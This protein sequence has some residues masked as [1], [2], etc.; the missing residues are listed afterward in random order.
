MAQELMPVAGMRFYIG[1]VMETQATDFVASDFT[2][3]HASP[4]AWVE[5]DGWEQMGPVGDSVTDIATQLINRGRTTHQKGVAD[6]PTMTNVFVKIPGD[7]GQTAL[8]AAAAPSDKNNYAIRISGSE[9]G[10][11]STSFI[12][13]LG[14]FMGAPEAGGGANTIRKI[15]A[16]VQINSNV[17]FVDSVA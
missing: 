14:L 7:D 3:A 13:L 16:N 6:A 2:T 10:V 1:K 17:V 15:T 4:D 5:V 11:S 8:I 12:Y 9:T